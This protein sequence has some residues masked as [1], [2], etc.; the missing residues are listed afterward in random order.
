MTPGAWILSLHREILLNMNENFILRS[1]YDALGVSML[2][3][4]PDVAD[5]TVAVL[6]LAHGMRGC[7]ERFLPFMEYMSMHGVACVAN[8]HRG[9]GASVRSAKDRGY[10]Y[11]GGYP[12]LVDDMKKVN[13]WAHSA[14]P[15]QPVFLLGHSMGSLAVRTF[16]KTH[17][18][19]VDGIFICGSPSY[20]PMAPFMYRFAGFLS[21]FK[22]GRMRPRLIQNMTSRMYNRRFSSEGRNAWTCSDASVRKMFAENPSCNFHFTANALLALFGMMKETYS[23]EGWH[24]TNPDLPVYFIS[25]G[26]D[27]CM[28]NESEFHKSAQLMADLGYLDVS[29]AIYPGM[30]HEVLNEIG[31]E[32]VWEDILA[33][34]LSKH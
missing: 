23:A 19:S 30:R 5:D 12:A 1:R 33:H 2:V 31:K 9:H 26:D 32:D 10:M 3:T 8:D 11:S 4:R 16:M 18:D 34:I 24:V 28:R 15:G 27:P 25:G 21:L 29:S 7:K 14:F 6:Q 13:E 20:N 22:E 17:D